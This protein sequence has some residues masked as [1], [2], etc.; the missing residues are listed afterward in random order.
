MADYPAP[1]RPRFE[2]NTDGEDGWKTYSD[3]IHPTSEFEVSVREVMRELGDLLISKQ[4]DYGPKNISDSPY[5]PIQGLVVRMW[6]KIARIVNLTRKGNV[7][8]EN[9]PLED[10]FKDIANYGIIGLLVLRGKWDN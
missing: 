6:D 5:G 8:V 1:G 10:S 7:T 4:N 3:I 9:E 2:H